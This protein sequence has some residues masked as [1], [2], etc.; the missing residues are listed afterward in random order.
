M[1]PS[2]PF[3]LERCSSRLRSAILAEFQGRHPTLQ[4]VAS[5]PPRRWLTAPGVGQTL[6]T[7]LEAII[8]DHQGWTKS[9]VPATSTDA[10]L[11]E[12]IEQLQR[13]LERLRR[14]LRSVI[15]S[16]RRKQSEPDISDQ[17]SLQ[18]GEG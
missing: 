1:Q 3:P 4:E 16:I 7:E 12:R 9:D 14:E 2:D 13:D 6:L 15:D 17:D 5:I 10:A 8:R 11:V 18:G